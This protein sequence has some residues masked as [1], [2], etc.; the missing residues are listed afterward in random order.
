[1]TPALRM[2]AKLAVI[3]LQCNRRLSS[4][5]LPRREELLRQFD[6]EKDHIRDARKCNADPGAPQAA[7]FEIIRDRRESGCGRNYRRERRCEDLIM[8]H[9]MPASRT[10]FPEAS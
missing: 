3:G 10:S 5:S 6:E 4:C 2:V 8:H 7:A 9:C 1:M